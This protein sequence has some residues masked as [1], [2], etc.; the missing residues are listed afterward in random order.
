[1]FWW[2]LWSELNAPWNLL[3]L[4]WNK[5]VFSPADCSVWSFPF[6]NT[7]SL[8]GRVFASSVEAI[9][10]PNPGAE[11][12]RCRGGES[13]GSE[14]RVI[15]QKRTSSGQ[16]FACHRLFGDLCLQKT[17]RG[18]TPAYCHPSL[19]QT[20]EQTIPELSFRCLVKALR[21]RGRH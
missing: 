9:Q 1:M 13:P 2:M 19:K 3:E 5:S 7:P 16:K 6:P 12:K 14:I 8:F 20:N 17:R 18:K 15:K 10:R 21:V 11:G 4:Y